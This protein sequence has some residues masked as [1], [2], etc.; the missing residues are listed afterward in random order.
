MSHPIPTHEHNNELEEDAVEPE[1]T[2]TDDVF[3]FDE[4]S[5]IYKL[6]GKKLTG[7]TTILGVI[8]KPALV[9]WAARM[10]VEH[11]KASISYRRLKLLRKGYI[12]IKEKALAEAQVLTR[13]RKRQAARRAPT[14]MRS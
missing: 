6:N 14:L 12:I 7:V 8:N 4:K 13:K 3:E 11:I 5:H 1:N 10:A 9:G 2:P